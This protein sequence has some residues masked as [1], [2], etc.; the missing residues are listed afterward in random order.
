MME[1]IE[2]PVEKCLGFCWTFDCRRLSWP[3]RP[4]LLSYCSPDDEDNSDNENVDNEDDVDNKDSNNEDDNNNGDNKDSDNEDVENEDSNNKD[5]DND[6][7]D[8]ED[9]TVENIHLIFPNSVLV[10]PC[11]PAKVDLIMF[12]VFVIVIV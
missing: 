7:R 10:V 4:S 1:W 6:A 5:G 3:S 8:N 12:T 2:D 11:K 9:Y